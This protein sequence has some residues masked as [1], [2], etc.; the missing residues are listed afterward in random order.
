MI[1]QQHPGYA[2]NINTGFNSQPISFCITS[3]YYETA[4]TSSEKSKPLVIDKSTGILDRRTTAKAVQWIKPT[5]TGQC[6]SDKDW[7]TGWR[8][9]F[10]TDKVPLR[11]HKKMAALSSIKQMADNVQPSSSSPR[12]SSPWTTGWNSACPWLQQ[13]N[14]LYKA[15]SVCRF[16]TIHSFSQ[17]SSLLIWLAYNCH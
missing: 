16:L 4:I 10:S 11:C 2:Q 1:P 17:S 12:R 13:N 9:T 3:K 5:T 7:T 8:M 14:N 15:T 6:C